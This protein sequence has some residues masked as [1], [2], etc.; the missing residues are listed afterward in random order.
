MT[1]RIGIRRE[2]KNIWERRVPLI[3]EH[4]KRL[5]K[6][7][8]IETLLQP[9]ESRAFSHQE[10][11]EA[12]ATIDENLSGCPIIFAVKEIPT[13]FFEPQKTY[14][15]FSHT[16]KGQAFNM[17]MLKRILDLNCNL[18]DYER[19][20]DAER[21]R[22]IF[23]GRYAGLSGM[24]DALWA[25]G[26][27]LKWEG[28]ENPFE[29]MRQAHHYESLA[30]AKAEIAKIGERISSN[31]LPSSLVPMICGFA[32]YGHVSK[33]AQEILDLLPT[34]EV[35]PKA[36]GTIEN[37]GKAANT[38]YKVVF[39]EEHLVEPI[40]PGAKFD[41][42]EYYQNPARYRSK[43]ATY[44]PYL[45]ILVNAIYWEPRYPKLVTKAFLREMFKNKS[46]PRL[47]VIGDISCDI[48]GAIECTVRSTEPGK[49][50]F[51]YDPITDEATDG[52]K[53]HGPVVM[54]VDNLPC[55]F[56]REASVEFS[57]ELFPFVPAIVYANYSV[58][59]EQFEVPEEI[60]RA[61]IVYQRQ[62]TPE[63]SYME[64][65]LR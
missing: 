54:A 45:S 13:D 27:R 39:K 3:P 46:Q 17:P 47:R 22:L 14:V 59:F 44:M 32:G 19:V 40:T 53:G 18:I 12:G 42:Q 7:H 6:E 29:D 65:F 8:G 37:S 48:E 43:F 21:R 55:E 10:Y 9:F 56:P 5:K 15:F 58:P 1:K 51:V 38:I 63:Y 25:F 50:V 61:V 62:L 64:K 24:V 34:V 11:I 33:G 2:D 31:G 20:V 26:R 4:V 57:Q 23:F 60:K 52:Y 30:E 41:L 36:L 16:I 35:V 28:V 49:P